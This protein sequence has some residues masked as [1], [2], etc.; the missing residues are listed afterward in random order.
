MKKRFPVILSIPGILTVF[1][2]LNVSELTVF[3]PL[4]AFYRTIILNELS[5]G[6]SPTRRR[7]RAMPFQTWLTQSPMTTPSPT[8]TRTATPPCP[9]TETRRAP[10]S[11]TDQDVSDSARPPLQQKHTASLPLNL[12]ST[13]W[14]S[15][16]HFSPSLVWL[17]RML[18][19][20][21]AGHWISRCS[22]IKKPI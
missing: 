13:L 7:R 4:L 17:W 2:V 1:L 16:G 19:P 18:Y 11:K 8:P 10:E 6:S 3:A 9:Q 20:R 22:S 12:I 15:T 14:A 5:T 21:A